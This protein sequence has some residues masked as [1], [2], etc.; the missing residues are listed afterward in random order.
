MSNFVR[1]RGTSEVAVSE[2]PRSPSQNRPLKMRGWASKVMRRR[3]VFKKRAF[4]KQFSSFVFATSRLGLPWL[5]LT[6]VV[7]IFWP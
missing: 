1:W 6:F 3:S 2:V 7:V 4:E 5:A